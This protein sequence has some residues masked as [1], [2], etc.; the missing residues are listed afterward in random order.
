MV[1]TS[2]QA[3][4][5]EHSTGV[6]ASYRLRE[7]SLKSSFFILFMFLARKTQTYFILKLK[8]DRDEDN[9]NIYENQHTD[10]F[11]YVLKA[12]QNI[13]LKTH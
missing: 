9:E 3:F 2:D 4:C 13:I 7:H 5:R 12:S 1:I 11:L 10:K 6:C 8:F